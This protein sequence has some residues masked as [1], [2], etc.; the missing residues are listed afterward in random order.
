MT[1]DETDGG[2]D[3]GNQLEGGEGLDNLAARASSAGGLTEAGM[4]SADIGAVSDVGR[5]GGGRTGTIS[6]SDP[7]MNPVGSGN[8][9]C[10]TT[11]RISYRHG[12]TTL[13]WRRKACHAVDSPLSGEPW[14][15]SLLLWS[16]PA[17]PSTPIRWQRT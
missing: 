3:Q 2:N 11:R 16:S 17:I 9:A 7:G 8:R 6:T 14:F 10:V 15:P 5:I 1:N 4:R 12:T 13:N